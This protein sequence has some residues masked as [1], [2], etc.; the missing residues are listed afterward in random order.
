MNIARE[1]DPVLKARGSRLLVCG[2]HGAISTLEADGLH[3]FGEMRR[4]DVADH[5]QVK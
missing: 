4:Y 5:Y 3:T 2:G 1:L